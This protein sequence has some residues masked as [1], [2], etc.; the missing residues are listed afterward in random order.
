MTFASARR[1]VRHLVPALIALAA[2][3]LAEERDFCPERPGLDT[4]PCIVDRARVVVEASA[5]DWRL[6]RQAGTRTDTVLVG[7]A[8]LRAGLTDR[9]E[10]QIGWTAYG[11]VRTRDTAGTSNSAGTGDVT[12]ALKLGLLN[13]GGGGLSVALKPS[14]S[15]PAGGRAIGAGTWGAG[16]QLPVGYSVAAGVQLIATPEIDSAPDRD[17]TGRHWAWGSGAGVQAALTAEVS[18]AAEAQLVRDNDPSEHSA[19]ALGEVSLAWQAGRNTQF[20][21]GMIAGLNHDG[22]DV[23]L[24]VGVARRF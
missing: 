11:H 5:V 20:D 15:L 4:P 21:A 7:D 19:Q 2:P 22:P 10:A 18:L 14:V 23:E 9:L 17:G 3:A 16:L 13:P 1:C 12:L 24:I 6:D 8:L